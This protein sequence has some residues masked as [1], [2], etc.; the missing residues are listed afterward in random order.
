MSK[1]W[2]FK[3]RQDGIT[4]ARG[5][6]DDKEDCVREAGYYLH[7]YLEE[8]FE[9]TTMEVKRRKKDSLGKCDKSQIFP[10]KNVKG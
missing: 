2:G 3:I 7:L 1:E 5:S 6:F 10:S 8:D 9:K 4:V